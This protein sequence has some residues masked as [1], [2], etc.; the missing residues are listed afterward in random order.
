MET[1]AASMR[2]LLTFLSAT[3]SQSPTT[4]DAKLG[5]RTYVPNALKDGTSTRKESAV[6]FPLSAVSSTEPREFAKHVTKATLLST[7]V[8]NSQIRT[9]DALNGT[10][11]FAEDVQKDGG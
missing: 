5:I 10:V 6:K 4:T 1:S 7:T 8:A 2:P 3:S 9:L 11:M